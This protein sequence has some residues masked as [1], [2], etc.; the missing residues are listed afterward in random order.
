MIL[1]A[2]SMIEF[3]EEINTLVQYYEEFVKGGVR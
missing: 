1:L 2:K 3:K